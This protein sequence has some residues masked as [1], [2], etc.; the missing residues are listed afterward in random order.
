MLQNSSALSWPT[1]KGEELHDAERLGGFQK[2]RAEL[3]GMDGGGADLALLEP[4]HFVLAHYG[5]GDR[6][7]NQGHCMTSGGKVLLWRFLCLPPFFFFLSC[8]TNTMTGRSIADLRVLCLEGERERYYY[9]H[10]E[11]SLFLGGFN[12]CLACLCV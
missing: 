6:K 4:A 5:R 9:Y 7:G 12:V 3:Y 11:L 1:K 8:L 10:L 2:T